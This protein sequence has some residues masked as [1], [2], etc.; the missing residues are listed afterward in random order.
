MCLGARGLEV[1]AL[2]RMCRQLAL[3]P[4]R[5][6]LQR[7]GG[8]KLGCGGERAGPSRRSPIPAAP[9]RRGL[10]GQESQQLL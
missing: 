4:G 5:W 6:R 1:V 9:L 2:G 7:L 8:R 3:G 10:E